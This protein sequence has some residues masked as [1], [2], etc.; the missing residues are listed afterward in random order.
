MPASTYSGGGCRTP[1]GGGVV[2]SAHTNSS[3]V[4][5]AKERDSGRAR[6]RYTFLLNA[7]VYITSSV[8]SSPYQISALARCN[9]LLVG[10]SRLDIG[11][12]VIWLGRSSSAR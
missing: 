3:Y 9:G 4:R 12:S 1:F 11:K 8:F 5:P 10:N 6:A 7:I 2:L